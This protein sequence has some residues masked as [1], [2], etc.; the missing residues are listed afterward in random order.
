MSLSFDLDPNSKLRKRNL[1]YEQLPASKATGDITDGKGKGTPL[2]WCLIVL[3][4]AL[5][6]GTYVWLTVEHVRINDQKHHHSHHDD[7]DDDSAPTP[8]P[9]TP[10]PTP[11]PIAEAGIGTPQYCNVAVHCANKPALPRCK[12]YICL[13]TPPTQV[14]QCVV[15]NVSGC[16]G[17][18][19]NPATKCYDSSRL[20]MDAVNAFIDMVYVVAP[21]HAFFYNFPV[22][23]NITKIVQFTCWTEACQAANAILFNDAIAALL[24][25]VET[26]PYLTEQERS[27]LIALAYHDV[28]SHLSP[29]VLPFYVRTGSGFNIMW[30]DLFYWNSEDE[31]LIDTVVPSV[32]YIVQQWNNFADAMPEYQAYLE[33]N[34]VQNR[35]ESSENTNLIIGRLCSRVEC[36]LPIPSTI[37]F[38]PFL[39]A[40]VVQQNAGIAAYQRCRDAIYSMRTYL[41][42]TYVATALALRGVSN[43]GIAGNMVSVDQDAA[44]LAFDDLLRFVTN[45]KKTPQE[46]FDLGM[47]EMLAA[48]AATVVAVNNIVPVA[49]QVADFAEFKLKLATDPTF[50]AYLYENITVATF[51]ATLLS[52][53]QEL[54]ENL[55]RVVSFVPRDQI[56]VALGSPASG[57]FFDGPGP[58]Q[59]ITKS[60]YAAFGRLQINI[61]VSPTNQSAIFQIPRSRKFN[62][63]SHESIP[64][65]AL[66]SPIISEA[67]CTP[68]SATAIGAKEGW[69]LYAERLA[70]FDMTLASPATTTGKFRIL[71]YWSVGR[72]KRAWRM[73]ADT[74]IHAFGWSKAY[75]ISHGVNNT[76]SELT[77]IVADITSEVN[78]ML[79]RPGFRT[80][81]LVGALD[82]EAERARAEAELGD[83]FNLI[84]FNDLLLK[85]TASFSEVIKSR[86]DWYIAKKLAGT[87]STK[88]PF[89]VPQPAIDPP[90][91]LNAFTLP[92]SS[93]AA[94]AA[95]NDKYA[96][97]AERVA[98]VIAARQDVRSGP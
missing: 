4:G 23:S 43:P 27:N 53:I 9:A 84:E 63:I 72:L 64:G 56:L 67:A 89:V 29:N 15:A 19:F 39:N 74:G 28:N 24:N 48:Q 30:D 38:A 3:F 51:T 94:A 68:F 6:I 20:Y 11:S 21:Q 1:A 90:L 81:Y 65:H 95:N 66:Q 78:S 96:E 59:E 44:A 75:A 60:T 52:S 46:L 22:P 93:I 92:L 69:S 62:I 87:F 42:T 7:D 54:R 58:I 73:V 76:L 18:I 33:R 25:A 17:P 36:T 37:A 40:S 79:A 32:D 98:A 14:R 8:V 34:R 80:G 57:G 97:Y 26:I 83:S 71:E 5:I 50:V 82:I 91:A 88:V 10:P 85:Y 49:D 47:S 13:Y 70:A 41:N 55:L 77:N 12:E 61:G 2:T 31:S 16:D 86:V 35:T 45:T